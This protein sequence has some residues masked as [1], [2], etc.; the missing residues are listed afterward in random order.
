MNKAHEAREKA[1]APYSHFRVGA[2]L[3]LESGTIIS[4]NNQE[5]AAY[6][7]GLC[8]ERVAVYHAGAVY[9]SQKITSLAITARSLNKKITEP[10]PPCGA[11]RQALVEYEVKQESDIE[12]YFMGESGKI[13]K[14]NSIKDLLPLIFNKEYL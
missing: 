13:I 6:P 8:A 11:C 14:A 10:I 4:G 5:N 7:S 3:L 9:P 2:T 12:T 1:Y